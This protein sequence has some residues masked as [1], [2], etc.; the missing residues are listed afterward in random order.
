MKAFAHIIENY[1]FCLLNTYRIL[2]VYADVGYTE[3]LA[4]HNLMQ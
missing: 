4:Y 2:T 1:K 3:W